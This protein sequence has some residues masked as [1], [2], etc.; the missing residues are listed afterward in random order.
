MPTSTDT[1]DF[2][3][4]MGR[5]PTGI[6]VVTAV[7]DNTPV[8]FTCQSFVSLSL[9]PPLVSLAPAKTSTSWPRIRAAGAFCVNVLAESQLEL[10]LVFSRS[11]GDK[12]AGVDW[13]LGVLGTPRLAGS[14]AW[15][16][17][18]LEAIH[19]AGDH[20]IVVGRVIGL[21]N[22]GGSPLLFHERRFAKLATVEPA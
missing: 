2:K 17:C 14:A 20:E 12:F 16:E 15:I 22:G 13:S 3:E 8:G 4:I 19:D 11:G 21:D 1:A 10:C 5:F 9:Q 6:A 7:D 18:K